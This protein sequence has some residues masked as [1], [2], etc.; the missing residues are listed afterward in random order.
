MRSFVLLQSLILLCAVSLAVDLPRGLLVVVNSGEDS[1]T[2]VDLLHPKALAKIATRKHPQD[3]VVSPD[4]SLAYVAEMGTPAEPG[5]TIAVINLPARNIIKRLS[6]GRAT[7]PHLLALS[8]DGHTLWAACAP[9]NTIVDLDT[10]SGTIYKLWDTQQR[11]S[12]L[13]AVSPDEKKLYVTNFDAGTVSVIRRSDASVQVLALGGQPIG[14]DVAPDG[15]E[16]WVSNFRSNTITIIDAATDRI[17]KTL[18][19]VG[20]GP[21]RIKFTPNGKYVWVTNSRS[22]ELIVFDV[23]RRCVIRRIPTGKFSKGLLV[24]PDGHHAFVSAMEDNRVIEVD[25]PTR[26]VLQ[27]ISTGEAPEGLAW[28]SSR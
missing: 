21:A 9:Q 24:L 7:L 2:L 14:I 26:R 18:P 12:Y 13:L 1:V 5:N 28:V 23:A 6:L 4:G 11:G 25:V 17:A 27:T 10:S 19:A 20:D 8:H 16:V 22:N 15:S 3:V